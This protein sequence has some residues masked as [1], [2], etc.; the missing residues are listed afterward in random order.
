MRAAG[1]ERCWYCA[2]IIVYA[3]GIPGAWRLADA[4][5]S[6]AFTCDGWFQGVHLPAAVS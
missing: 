3:E 6:A 5:G 4:E 1:H 2:R